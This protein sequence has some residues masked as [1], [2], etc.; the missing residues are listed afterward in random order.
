MVFLRH[1]TSLSLNGVVGVSPQT[2]SICLRVL[3][4]FRCWF[5]ISGRLKQMEVSNGIDDAGT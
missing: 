2:P 5:E 1:N 3:F 4:M